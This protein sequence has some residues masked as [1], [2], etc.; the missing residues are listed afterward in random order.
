MLV[1]EVLVRRPRGRTTTCG[2]L[3]WWAYGRTYSGFLTPNTTLPDWI[4]KHQLCS[5]HGLSNPPCVNGTTNQY[6]TGYVSGSVAMAARSRHPGGVNVCFA[7][8]SVK[9][10]KNTVNPITYSA[11]SSTKGGEVVSADAY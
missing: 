6:P 8:G 2:L 9:F 5:F 11:L 3:S 1:S 4:R 7:D 10:I